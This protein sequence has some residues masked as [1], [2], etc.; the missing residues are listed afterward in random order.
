MVA[1]LNN[2]IEDHAKD[3]N[4][5]IIINN[6]EVGVMKKKALQPKYWWDNFY[7]YS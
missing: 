2:N 5:N 4:I 6:K 1:F 3:N 7:L